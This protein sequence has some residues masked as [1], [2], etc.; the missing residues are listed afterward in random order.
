M[1]NVGKLADGY[2]IHGGGASQSFEQGSSIGMRLASP[3]YP[4]FRL[5]DTLK[6][7]MSS[8]LS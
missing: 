3:G 4:Q 5:M 2:G 1:P 6:K 8:E 7:G